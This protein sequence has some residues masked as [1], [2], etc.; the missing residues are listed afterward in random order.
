MDLKKI[1]D[2]EPYSFT[3]VD[4]RDPEEFAEGHIPAAMNLPL[5]NFVSGSGVL[6]K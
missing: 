6:D 1:M 4:V 3:V 5:K 2:E